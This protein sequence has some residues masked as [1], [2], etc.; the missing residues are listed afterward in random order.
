VHAFAQFGST[1]GKALC[2]HRAGIR[3]A[4]GKH[5]LAQGSACLMAQMTAGVC[6][7]GLAHLPAQGLVVILSNRPGMCTVN[8]L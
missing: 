8:A 2:A 5:G 7:S 6:I 4:C 1:G 3:C